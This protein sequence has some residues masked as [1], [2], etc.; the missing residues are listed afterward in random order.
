MEQTLEKGTR[1]GTA[2]ADE[3]RPGTAAAGETWPETAVAKG[4]RCVIISG[5]EFDTAAEIGADDF[6]I[7]CDRGY[8]YAQ[9]LG[10]RPDLVI[11]DFDSY[12]GTTAAGIPVK[13][14]P[15]R[16]DDTDTMAAVRY[17]AEQGFTA[18][19]LCCALG[20]RADHT[21]ANYQCGVYAARRGIAFRIVSEDAAIQIVHNGALA[22]PRREGFSLSVF[23]VSDRSEGVTIRGSE[24]DVE[25]AVLVNE[26]PIGESN[27]WREEMATISVRE[28]TLAVIEARRPELRRATAGAGKIT[29]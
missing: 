8:V 7:A 28:G 15:T 18:I 24:Y 23:S 1:P 14:Y 19:C 11:G 27:A 22:L 3:T 10:V 5:G 25:D 6:V 9:R 16:K 13:R 21:Y 17:A 12:H 29:Y 26:F 20:G 4:T 2:A